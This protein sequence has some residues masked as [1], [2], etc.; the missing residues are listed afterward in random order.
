MSK[1]NEKEHRNAGAGRS[2]VRRHAANGESAPAADATALCRVA[3][4][5]CPELDALE[6][7]RALRKDAAKRRERIKRLRDAVRDGRYRV[8]PAFVATALFLEGG[9]RSP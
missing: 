2:S 8:H 1:K 9:H 6:I 5:L 3:A 4:R 7:R